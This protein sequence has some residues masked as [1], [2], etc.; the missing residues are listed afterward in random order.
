MPLAPANG[1]GM[2]VDVPGYGRWRL[3]HHGQLEYLRPAVG[4]PIKYFL[5]PVV[6]FLN[7]ADDL[8]YSHISMSGISGG[9]WTAT[10]AP[11]VDARIQSSY[12]VAGSFPLRLYNGLGTTWGDYEQNA[13]DVFSIADYSEWYIIGACNGKQIQILNLYDPCCFGGAG[14]MSYYEDVKSRAAEL[15]CEWDLFSDDSIRYHGIS[16]TARAVI[17][18]D[19]EAFGAIRYYWPVILKGD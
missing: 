12:P 2:E 14:W 5:E 10:M 18:G 19:L 4:H 11:A 13:Y 7:Y 9:G 8:G 17:F 3:F 1:D 6:V 15:G 16:P